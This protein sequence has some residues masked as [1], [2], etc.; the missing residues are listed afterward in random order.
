[1]N[2]N[3]ITDISQDLMLTMHNGINNF[4]WWKCILYVKNIHTRVDINFGSFKFL[5][6]INYSHLH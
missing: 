1:M 3:I 4:F 6:L 5:L 2:S